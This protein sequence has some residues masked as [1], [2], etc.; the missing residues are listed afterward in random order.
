MQAT[1]AQGGKKGVPIIPNT[2]ALCLQVYKGEALPNIH[3]PGAALLQERH[4]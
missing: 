1:Q 3:H 2:G 4:L